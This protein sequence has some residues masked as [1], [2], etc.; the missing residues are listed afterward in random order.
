MQS[1]RLRLSEFCEIVSEPRE[2]V[3]SIISR[4]EAPFYR[5]EQPGKQRTFTGA[6]LVA[7][8]LFTQLRN[9]GVP[10]GLAAETVR[11]SGAVKAYLAGPENAR[12]LHLI[13]YAQERRTETGEAKRIPAMLTGTPDDVAAILTGEARSY[14]THTATGREKQGITGLV[15]VSID[16]CFRRCQAAA[17]QFGF[18]LIGGDL[19]EADE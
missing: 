14:G 8:C 7:W 2:T 3:R 9:M 19:V 16:T 17:E 13:L 5:I 4:D 12:D 6:D 15:A 18:A 1:T 11:T 10:A